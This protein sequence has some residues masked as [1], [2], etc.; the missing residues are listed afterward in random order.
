MRRPTVCALHSHTTLKADGVFLGFLKNW[1][2]NS[3][4][5]Y[6]AIAPSNRVRDAQLLTIS[7]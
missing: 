2:E 1:I 4:D 7:P 6:K 3:L 5:L